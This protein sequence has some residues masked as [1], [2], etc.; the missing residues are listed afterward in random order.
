VPT[1]TKSSSKVA[2]TNSLA[3][4]AAIASGLFTLM[5]VACRAPNDRRVNEDSYAAARARMVDADLR[6]R[7]IA[8]GRVL[9]AMGRV[10]R[11]QFV[12]PSYRSQAYTDHPLPIGRGQT[13]S[14]PY[15][16]ALM[17]ELLELRGQERVLDVGTGSGYQAAV[18]AEIARDVVSVEIEP[19]LAAEA[20]ARLRTLGYRNVT[21]HAGDGFF[22]WEATAPYDAIVVA[23]A[24]PRAPERLVGQ[25]AEGGRL[26]MPLGDD[27]S[28]QLI[29]GR[30]RGRELVIEAI[31][32]VLFVPMTG[33]VRRT[34]MR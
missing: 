17:T 13:I 31:T 24:A 32:D 5:I 15:V 3:S 6:G 25:L 10:P 28:Q 34:P 21:V 9:A 16:V 8:D 27:H 4:L 33:E 2:T 11:E 12:A 7:G 1:T 23:A 26:V 30:K 29:R 18:L 22:G 19:E 20:T 14:Q